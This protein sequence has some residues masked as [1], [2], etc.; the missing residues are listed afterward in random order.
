MVGLPWDGDERGEGVADAIGEIRA[1]FFALV[2][3]FGKIA[4][5]VRLSP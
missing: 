5:Y 4:M 3:S 2:G 1:A